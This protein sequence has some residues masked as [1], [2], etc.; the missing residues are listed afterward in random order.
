VRC[1]LSRVSTRRYL[2]HLT[3]QGLAEIHLRYGS[4]G[5]PEHGYRWRPQ[6]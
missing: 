6:S 3:A 4:A 2:E 1:G 5:R